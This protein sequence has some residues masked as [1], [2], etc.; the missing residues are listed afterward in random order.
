MEETL[1]I[2]APLIADKD[3]DEEL[4]P[5][6]VEAIADEDIQGSRLLLVKRMTEAVDMDG[7]RGGLLQ[8]ACSFQP[9]DGTRFSSA[10]LKL[11]L[12]TPENMHIIDLA[13]RKVDDTHPVE[14]T[15]TKKG[16]LG[17]KYL[18]F[19]PGG[20][21][22]LSKKFVKYH[23]SV[24]GTGEGTRLARWDLKENPDSK[25]GIGPEQVLTVTL[26]VTGKV[27]AEIIVT[28]R[29]VKKSL[30][31][32]IEAIRDLI[33]GVKPGERFYP[34]EFEIPIKESENKNNWFV[35]VV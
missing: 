27:A 34:V 3:A 22:G 21:I 18:S 35:T 24:H 33:L 4:G 31:G 30:K 19:E 25:V 6:G 1:L 11:R 2:D 28:A 5:G 32:K 8:F 15:L 13:P 7:V 14:F 10:Q 20:E 23:C 17:I 26:P 16:Q 12:K 29:L 9:A